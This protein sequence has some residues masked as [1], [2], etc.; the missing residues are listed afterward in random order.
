MAFIRQAVNEHKA[1]AAYQ[2]AVDAE[3]YYKGE[4][5]T[6]TKYDKIIYDMKGMA[7]KDMYTANHKIKSQFFKLV[8]NQLKSYLLGNGVSFSSDATKKKLGDTFDQ[9]MGKAAKYAQIDGVSFG[10][11][12]FDHVDVFKLTEFAPLYD[13]ET[14]ALMAGVR[15]W[16]LSNNKPIRYTLYEL[17]GFTEYIKR[18]GE[19]MKELKAKRPYKISVAVSGLEEGQILGGENYPT[20]PVIPLKN[21][22]DCLSE[23]VGKQNT[24]DALDLCRSGMVNNV[25]EGALIYWALTNCGGMSQEDA[26]KFLYTVK[27]THV[28]FIDNAEDGASAEPHSIEAPYVGTQTAIDGLIK[29]LYE[30]FQAFDSSAVS[31][32]NQTATAIKASYVP[33]D[34]K[35][36][37]FEEQVTTFILGILAVAGIDDEPSYTRNKI[38]NT[39]EEVNTIMTAA[40]RFDDEYVTKKLL[41]VMGDADQYEDLMKRKAAEDLDRFD[42]N[43]PQ[44]GGNEPEEGAR[45]NEKI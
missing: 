40:D 3:L 29:Q 43:T 30:D 21:N 18:S 11:W 22:D 26:E 44:D 15:F 9:Q 12:N 33:L 32:G 17:D 27:T 25:D 20:F 1:S 36:D 37:D 13:E 35:A 14:G 4:N 42:G 10:F 8:V 2:T 31:A 45:G 5:P 7:H 16:Q 24:L 23:L 41:T 28:A 6:I 38:I 39:Q 34:L 19:D